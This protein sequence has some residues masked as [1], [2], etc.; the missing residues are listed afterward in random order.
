MNIPS[1]LESFPK[2]GREGLTGK[3]IGWPKL[4]KTGAYGSAA[5]LGKD[6][7]LFR[8]WKHFHL[9]HSTTSEDSPIFFSQFYCNSNQ[10]NWKS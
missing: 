5:I 9:D 7:P 3:S 1:L 8:E 10:I 6:S 2:G 4:F